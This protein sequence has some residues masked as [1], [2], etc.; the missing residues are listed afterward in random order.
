MAC[1]SDLL[2]K[3]VIKFFILWNFFN[4]TKKG[5]KVSSSPIAYT[6]H[7]GSTY[8]FDN[9]WLLNTSTSY[10]LS[11]DSFNV[12]QS[13]LYTGHD[14]VSLNN[15]NILPIHCIGHRLLSS[16]HNKCSFSLK[17]IL[18]TSRASTKLLF[19][20]KLSVDNKMFVEFYINLFFVMDKG[21]F[22]CKENLEEVFTI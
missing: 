10:H 3:L 21:G 14:G 22:S 2:T 19:V 18:H 13:T 15:R 20:H 6:A 17:H 5:D 11:F 1:V 4:K 16:S 7:T 8:A 9:A 12:P